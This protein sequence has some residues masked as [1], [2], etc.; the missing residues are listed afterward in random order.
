M[1]SH[2]DL[3][4]PDLLEFRPAEGVIRLHEQRVLLVSAVAF[5]LL[6]RELIATVGLREARRLLVRFGFTNGY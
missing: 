6:R 3:R 1:R 2:S 5:G 4:L